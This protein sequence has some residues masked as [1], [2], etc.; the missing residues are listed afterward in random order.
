MMLFRRFAWTSVI[1]VAFASSSAFAIK[2]P[3]ASDDFTLNVSVLAQ[4]RAVADFDGPPT[5]GAT[6]QGQAPDG[7]FN[8]DFFVRRARLGAS[9]TVFK[10]FQFFIL[11]DTPNFGRRGDYTGSTFVQELVVGMEPWKDVI[12]EG[13]FLDTLL[14]H[15]QLAR[16]AATSIVEGPAFAFDLLNNARGNRMTGVQTR[17]LLFDHRILIRGGFYEG[18]RFFNAPATYKGPVVN[19]SGI[20]LVAAMVRYNLV[21]DETGSGMPGIYLDGK[22]RISFGVAGHY[23]RK[24]SWIPDA[25]GNPQ[26]VADYKVYA[27]DMFVDYV[28]PGDT[29]AVMQLAGYRFDYGSNAAGN[30]S[31]RTGFGMAGDVGYRFGKIEPQA[32]IYWF[33]SDTKQNSYFRVAGG[34]NYF[35]HG[36][37]AKLVAE[38]SSMINNGNLSTTPTLKELILQYQIAF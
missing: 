3:T 31:S 33:N 36:H 21:G 16:S 24:G 6:P 30:G 27:A 9:G 26:G 32:N 11:F 14:T 37:D 35:F 18:R 4:A 25:A 19:P 5:T 10:Q 22:S 12:I 1:G 34:V 28:L 7:S 23:Q 20:P 38:F 2:I 13:G 17:T 29:E 15:V 8:T